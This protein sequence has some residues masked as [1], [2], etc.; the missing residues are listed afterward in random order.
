M[1][2]LKYY[3]DLTIIPIHTLVDF[4]GKL[5]RGYDDN[6]YK[7]IK[8]KTIKELKSYWTLLGRNKLK[9]EAI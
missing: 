7:R 3:L 1:S 6:V 8:F 5:P 2:N 4:Y 9:H